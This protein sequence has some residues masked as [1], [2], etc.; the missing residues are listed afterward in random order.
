MGTHIYDIQMYIYTY[1]QYKHSYI[2]IIIYIFEIQKERERGETIK[3]ET[4]REIEK[5][6][7]N[8]IVHYIHSYLLIYM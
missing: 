6:R 4:E 1:I 3:R 5:A 2:C 7:H 8:V